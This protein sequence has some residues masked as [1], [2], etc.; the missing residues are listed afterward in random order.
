MTDFNITLQL[1]RARE[2]FEHGEIENAIETLDTIL[3]HEPNHPEALLLEARSYLALDDPDQA[4]QRYQSILESGEEIPLLLQAEAELILHPESPPLQTFSSQPAEKQGAEGAFLAAIAHYRGGN[5]PQTRTDLITAVKKGF[6]W[7]DD[8]PVDF[9]AQYLIL[10]EDFFDFE[11]LYLDAEETVHQGNTS[12][13]NRWFALN[14]PIIEMLNAGSSDRQRERAEYLAELINPEN[15]PVHLE[16]MADALPAIV[17]DFTRNSED[18]RF[19]LEAKK[20]LENDSIEELAKLILAMQL[21]HLR[22][23]APLLGHEPKEIQTRQLQRL[24]PLL[25]HRIA[26]TVLFLYSISGSDEHAQHLK[27]TRPEPTLLRGLITL[28]WTSFYKTINK[29]RKR[30]NQS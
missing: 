10:G 4:R 18:A 7:Q 15:K 28:C 6:E 19:G 20:H 30:Q 13:Q 5:I 2:Q 25:P 22:Q 3:E 27:D 21:E 29:F 1:T 9:I 23:F 14:M 11:Q 26:L 17:S 12:P 16:S 24:I 8:S